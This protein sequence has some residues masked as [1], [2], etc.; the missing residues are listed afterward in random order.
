ML[1]DQ[2]F[3]VG[4]R[5]FYIRR[6][7]WGTI[8]VIDAR[9]NY[10][11]QVLMDNDCYE[12]FKLDGR[13]YEKD[14]IPGIVFEEFTYEAPK[15]KFKPTLIGKTVHMEHRHH[16]NPTVGEITEEDELTIYIDGEGYFRKEYITSLVEVTFGTQ[17][18]L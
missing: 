15:R 7:V 18:L 17:N 13:E 11:V 8:K 6:G 1:F 14:V 5:V 3:Q 16:T 4:D 12:Y 9:D 10:P 2:G